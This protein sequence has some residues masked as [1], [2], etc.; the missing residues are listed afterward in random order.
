MKVY[1][2]WGFAEKVLEVASVLRIRIRILLAIL[3]G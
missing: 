3:A 1:Q 2:R